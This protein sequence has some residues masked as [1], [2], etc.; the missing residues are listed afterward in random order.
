MRA[1]TTTQP[2]PQTRAARDLLGYHHL[3]GTVPGGFRATLFELWSKADYT[4]RARLA[5]AFPDVA[6]AIAAMREG[7]PEALKRL[8]DVT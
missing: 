5:G 6:P 3:G 4:N 2:S 8:A 7:G 1:M